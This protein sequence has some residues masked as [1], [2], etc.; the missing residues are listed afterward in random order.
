M[1]RGILR[2][3]GSVSPE[4]I[5]PPPPIGQGRKIGLESVS[6]HCGLQLADAPGESSTPCEP[7]RVA[8]VW[9]CGDPGGAWFQNP[10]ST[11][12]VRGGFL[13]QRRM[14]CL[15]RS[16]PLPSGR[17]SL[18][19]EILFFIIPK[20]TLLL[21]V[22]P[23][24]HPGTQA[25]DRSL[26]PQLCPSACS[27]GRAGRSLLPA[28]GTRQPHDR[29]VPF[30]RVTPWVIWSRHRTGLGRAG[31]PGPE[32]PSASVLVLLAG[33]SGSRDGDI[34]CRARRVV[35]V[36]TPEGCPQARGATGGGDGRGS[37]AG[38]GP[39]PHLPRPRRDKGKEGLGP[40]AQGAR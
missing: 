33:S 18:A 21:L 11:L 31:A 38:T 23:C 16:C 28:T 4:P 36:G 12:A 35:T 7:G 10:A 15:D 9:G 5:S 22:S 8:L 17:T 39:A 19:L 14:V 1:A 2:A 24:C 26:C 29:R 40:G 3:R 37:S 13:S 20:C 6:G 30:L 32:H 34:G 25:P 27:M